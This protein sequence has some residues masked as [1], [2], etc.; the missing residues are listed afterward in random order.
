MIH[1]IHV[2]KCRDY[3]SHNQP[4]QNRRWSKLYNWLFYHF[5]KTTNTEHKLIWTEKPICKNE[6]LY[7]KRGV[8]FSC[9][10]HKNQWK[11]NELNSE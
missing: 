3:H 1:D 10:L 2:N 4:T 11:Q 8:V 6:N 7:V 5:C 9:V